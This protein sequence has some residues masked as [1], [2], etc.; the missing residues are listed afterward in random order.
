[1]ST[2]LL[3]EA[4][5]PTLNLELNETSLDVNNNPLMSTFAFNETSP[6]TDNVLLHIVRPLMSTVSSRNV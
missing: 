1:M 2:L 5:D 3:N 6:V 4:S